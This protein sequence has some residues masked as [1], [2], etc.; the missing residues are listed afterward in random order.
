MSVLRS[1][2]DK[3]VCPTANQNAPLPILVYHVQ[4]DCL[5]RLR[6]VNVI[7]FKREGVL[8]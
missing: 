3:D 1:R 5:T 8:R 7:L 6:K 2:T 4:A